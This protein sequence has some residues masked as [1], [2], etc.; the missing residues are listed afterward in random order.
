MF[1]ILAQEATTEG[2]SL[3]ILDWAIVVLFVG[4]ALFA[5]CR[6]TRRN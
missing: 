5:I 6:K 1:W 3:P 2:G 4:A